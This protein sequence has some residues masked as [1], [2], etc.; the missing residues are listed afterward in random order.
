MP[1]EVRDSNRFICSETDKYF[2]EYCQFTSF[3]RQLGL[4]LGPDLDLFLWTWAVPGNRFSYQV[5]TFELVQ[6]FY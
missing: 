6:E 4:G 3:H 2:H 5:Q 1:V